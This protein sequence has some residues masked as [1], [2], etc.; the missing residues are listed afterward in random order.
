[1][2]QCPVLSVAEGCEL[3]RIHH[4]WPEASRYR[5]CCG[6]IVLN[7]R[8]DK[9][10]E[11]F[12]FGG[13]LVIDPYE[14]YTTCVFCSPAPILALSNEDTLARQFAA[15]VLAMLAEQQ[16]VW[17]LRQPHEDFERRLTGI[18][19]MSLY[20]ACLVSMRTRLQPIVAGDRAVPSLLHLLARAQRDLELVR[21]WPVSPI[22]L[23]ELLMP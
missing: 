22:T 2:V 4:P 11:A 21:S 6:L 1:V 19:P 13:E 10:I 16:A 15:E 14:T 7:D 18:D 20:L 12:T 3:L 9:R 8:K 23:S 5:V 17:N